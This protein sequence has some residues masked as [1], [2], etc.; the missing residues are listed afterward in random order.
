M[1]R[2]TGVAHFFTEDAHQEEKND[3][4]NLRKARR[5]QAQDEDDEVN[6]DHDCDNYN[7]NDNPTKLC[8][9]AIAQRMQAQFQGCVI[10]RTIDSRDWMGRSLLNIPPYKAIHAILDLTERE[11]AVIAKKAEEVKDG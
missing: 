2:L 11:M 4:A 10:R 8:Q 9:N 1:G 6:K 5:E 3:A 7:D